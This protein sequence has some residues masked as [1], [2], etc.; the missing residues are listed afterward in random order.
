[1]RRLVGRRERSVHAG[2]PAGEPWNGDRLACNRPSADVHLSF[3]AVAYMLCSMLPTPPI[4]Q[5]RL[6][7]GTTDPVV[8]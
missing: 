3:D 5:E 1:M 6:L 7:A 8:A 2:R 4:D